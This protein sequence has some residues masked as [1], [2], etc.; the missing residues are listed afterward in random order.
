V[1]YDFDYLFDNSQEDSYNGYDFDSLFGGESSQNEDPTDGGRAY[2]GWDFDYLFD[3]EPDPEPEQAPAFGEF[4]QDPPN[5]APAPVDTEPVAPV[6]DAGT[7]FGDYPRK[8]ALGLD[9]FGESVGRA[10][11]IAGNYDPT[12]LFTESGEGALDALGQW[13]ENYYKER[14]KKTRSELSP[15]MRK[16]EQLKYTKDTGATWSDEPIE[17]FKSLF[18]GDAWKSPAKIAGSFLESAP[19][20][21]VGMG[22]GAAITGNLLKSALV[23]SGTISKGLAGVIGGFIGEGSVAGFEAGKDVYD[24][25]E[26]APIDVLSKTKEYQT[27]WAGLDGEG[28]SDKEREKKSRELVADHAAIKSG[29]MVFGMTG[30]LGSVSGHYIGK[31]MGGEATGG[32]ARKMATAGG[33]ELLQETPQSGYEALE[34]NIQTKKFVNPEQDIWEGVEEASIEGGLQGF[35]M[36]A[37]LGGA[38]PNVTQGTED[39]TTP[40]PPA[41]PKA[42]KKERLLAKASGEID[43][44]G[45]R[46]EDQKA[47]DRTIDALNK[48][49]RNTTINEY[50]Q[51]ILNPETETTYE[52]LLKSQFLTPDEQKRIQDRVS[53]AQKE[54]AKALEDASKLARETQAQRMAEYDPAVLAELVTNPELFDA[55]FPGGR[56]EDA[57]PYIGESTIG[58]TEQL[59]EQPEQPAA[60]PENMAPEPP[61]EAAKGARIDENGE[62]GGEVKEKAEGQVH[63]FSSTQVDIPKEESKALQSFGKKIPD[64]EIYEDPKDPSYGR[65]EEPHITVKYGLDTVDP[66]EVEPLL[67]GQGPITAKMGKVSI[68]ESDAYDVVK[69]DIESSELHALNKKIADNLKVTDTYPDYKP[70]ATIAYVK[71]G[72]GKKYIGDKSFEGKEVVF[73]SLTF[74]GKDGKLTEIPLEGKPTTPDAGNKVE[75]D[76]AKIQEIKN[77]IAEGEQILKSGMFNGKKRDQAYLDMVQRSVDNAKAKMGEAPDAGKVEGKEP[78]E[79]SRKEWGKPPIGGGMTTPLYTMSEATIKIIDTKTLTKEVLANM[80]KTLKSMGYDVRGG[81]DV[82]GL[83][84][85]RNGKLVNEDWVK[86][87]RKAKATVEKRKTTLKSKKDFKNIEWA[88]IKELGKTNDLREAGYIAKDGS[89]IDLSG[90][91]EGGEPGTRSYDHREAGG[92]RGMKELMAYGYIRMDDNS[93]SMDIAKEPT[94]EQYRVIR[95]IIDRHKG[96]VVV[97]LEDGLGELKDQYYLSPARSFSRKYDKGIPATRVINDIKRFFSGEVPLPIRP[98]RYSMSEAVSPEIDTAA[99]ADIAKRHN[100]PAESLE[101]YAPWDINGKTLHLYNVDAPGNPKD[102]STLAY[103]PTTAETHYVQGDQN[104]TPKPVGADPKALKQLQKDVYGWLKDVLPRSVLKNRIAVELTPKI[105]RKGKDVS[106]SEAQ[107]SEIKNPGTIMGAATVDKLNAFVELSY[108]FDKGTIQKN[109]Y[110]ESFHVA[111]RWLLPDA[112]Y[113]TVMDHFGGNEEKAAE[114]FA[115]FV[116]R[117]KGR[118][119]QPS[120]ILRI[121]RRLRLVFKRVRNGLQGQGFKTAEDV[122]NKLWKKGYPLLD[123]ETI[124]RRVE[125]DRQSQ[126]QQMGDKWYS[127]MTN[128]LKQKLPGSGSPKQ[129]AQTLKSWADKGEYKAEELEWSG[130]LDWLDGKDG[131]VSKQEVLDYLKQNNVQIQEVV[132]SDYIPTED[133]I[134]TFLD[135][136]LGQ[137]YT[138]DEARV[139]LTDPEADDSTEY[140]EYQTP[141]GENYKELLLTLPERGV[142]LPETTGDYAEMLFGKPF[143]EL[144]EDQK[145]KVI[146]QMRVD[147]GTI[148]RKEQY[149]SSHWD[150]PNVLAHVRFNERTD[151]DGNRV[152]FVEEIQSD[153]HQEGR[154]KGYRISAKERK[155]ADELQRKIDEIGLDALPSKERVEAKQLGEKLAFEGVPNFPFKKTWPLMAF[156]RMVRY[157]ASNGFDAISWTPGEVQADRYDLSK[158]VSKVV[159]LKHASKLK[160]YGKNGDEVIDTYATEKTLPDIIGKEAAEKLIASK[161]NKFKYGPTQREGVEHVLE[162]EDLKVG[163]EGMKGFYDKI[164][165][166]AVNKFFNKKA[167]GKAKVGVGEIT[168]Q[169][170]EQRRRISLATGRVTGGRKKIQIGEPPGV[171]VWTLPITPEMRNKAISEGMPMF[172]YAG[173]K[174]ID[175]QA[176][177]NISQRHNVPESSLKFKDKWVIPEINKTMYLYNVDK[178]GHPKDKS[179]LAY[180]PDDVRFDRVTRE[181][182][183][184]SKY[185]GRTPKTFEKIKEEVSTSFKKNATT[186]IFDRFNPIKSVG[187]EAYKLFRLTTGSMSTFKRFLIDGKIEMTDEGLPIVK[188]KGK[189]VLSWFKELKGNDAE[190]LLTWA[191][192]KRAEVLDS[193]DRENW[194]TENARKEIMETIPDKPASGGTWEEL[195]SKFQEY[196]K[197][198]LDYAEAS[199]LIDGEARKEWEQDFYVPFYRLIEDGSQAFLQGPMQSKKH[200]SAGIKRLTGREAQIGDL[201]ENTLKN[202]SHMIQ[203]ANRNVAT[204]AAYAGS[205][206]VMSSMVDVESGETL[207]AMQLMA[208]KDLIKVLGAKTEK[209][210]AVIKRGSQRAKKVLDT[211]EDAQDYIKG[212]GKGYEIEPRTVKSVMMTNANDNNVISFYNKGKQ[213]NVKINDPELFNAMTN[214][215]AVRMNKL[216][217]VMFGGPKKILTYGATFGPAFRVANMIRDT[218]HTSIISKSFIPF[219]DT[220]IGFGKALREDQ[221]WINFQSSNAGQGASYIHS[222]DPQAMAKYVKRVIKKD[223]SSKRI[224]DSPKKL[225]S[226][227]DWWEAIGAAS[228][229]AARVQLFTKKIKEG[230]SRFDAAFEAR[231]LLDFTMRGDSRTVQMLIRMLPFANARMQG[232]YKLG[233]AAKADPKSVGLKLGY[234]TLTSIALWGLAQDDDDFDE[235][236][237]QLEDWE[238]LAYHNFWIG[239]YQFRIPRTFE[240]GILPSLIE[241]ALDTMTGTDEPVHIFK[242]IGNSVLN[243]L[244]FNPMPQVGRP[245][246]EQWAG[247]SFFTGRPIEGMGMQ[248]L[249]PSQRKSPYTSITLNTILNNQLADKLGVSPVRA[250]ALI[251][252]YFSTVGMFALGISDMIVRSAGDFPAKPTIPLSQYPLAGRFLRDTKSQQHSKFLTKLY[253]LTSDLNQINSTINDY[254][255]LGKREEA[256]EL[257][258][259]NRSKLRFRKALNRT[260]TKI[261]KINRR[262]ERILASTTLTAEQKRSQINNLSQRKLRY[263]EDAVQR[264]LKNS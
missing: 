264:A 107:W 223:G 208:K 150:E 140:S 90:K 91:S 43:T 30:L 254:R 145:D 190:D 124:G 59:G 97:D 72:E 60:S 77:S 120:T 53:K 66:K 23:N 226:F 197:N 200:I 166:A 231:D 183:I 245:I 46:P 47:A 214:V 248:N 230:K 261:S 119:R 104:G 179:T 17:K 13:T 86:A 126:Y 83:I 209:K 169:F 112:D 67:S 178:P 2:N 49:K 9:A 156:K 182:D 151:A 246:I 114:A 196:N 56:I 88:R 34:K 177:A 101:Y 138:R 160:A 115:D 142:K 117:A 146:E 11:D 68:F 19:S 69:V 109:T 228:E 135:D 243:T 134:D 188:T 87:Y 50:T 39:T 62:W 187:M 32:I 78:W 85:K 176:R 51:D 95:K 247:K 220:A 57:I 26:K 186:R 202:W 164:L 41:D 106:K 249:L 73:K 118:D 235:H 76:P 54:Q 252:G 225:K 12:R 144:R 21:A 205:K 203:E 232:L 33:A 258:A 167:W 136:E 237:G 163:G 58:N 61:P 74:S 250:E 125:A 131:K 222:E 111:A 213:L 215:N 93:G 161:P 1:A 260:K 170:K 204:N 63:D 25:V 229:D 15:A 130:V 98:S 149:K 45:I 7:T 82:K 240:L 224:L 168:G 153:L 162:G 64:S 36:G 234:M 199:G 218:V 55:E 116:K 257:L 31:I 157:A 24:L 148:R 251:R 139:Y 29:A 128:F 35:L 99:R 65:E 216:M 110:H 102:K 165:P 217:S 122:F 152:L 242:A 174:N 113:K 10:I 108:G 219:W 155:R 37:G 147:E 241:A 159:W 143:N 255:V 201:F 185:F 40:P 256:R 175:Q 28:L 71:K 94:P 84:E 154:K 193:Q 4:E 195:N 38:V 211:M 27:A 192:V 129:I 141:G 75:T 121:F 253:N 194:L 259:D 123:Q 100:V 81:K 5:Y 96:E 244:A 18:Q 80:N 206:G 22:T 3:E 8:L 238:K 89:M 103:D 92:A 20:T 210:F 6:D 239:D 52:S 180:D 42:I 132:K 262:I 172:S 14:G 105:E 233:R 181:D 212:L 158:Q 79:M 48:L 171:E 133:D 189:G 44:T 173:E 127:Q 198:I 227:L 16:A 184:R 263:A 137:G 236:Y 191:A 207:P 221:D 70:H